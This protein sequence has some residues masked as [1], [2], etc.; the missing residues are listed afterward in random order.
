[1][2][3]DLYI[4]I[5]YGGLELNECSVCVT[6]LVM[7]HDSFVCVTW[8][9][10][11]CDMTRSYVWHAFFTH[12]IRRTRTKRVLCTCDMTHSDV[13]H[14]SSVCVT[15]LIHMC[16]MTHSYVWNDSFVC[17]TWLIPMCDI[18]YSYTR[19]GALELNE[20][21]GVWLAIQVCCSLLQPVAA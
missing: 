13:W 15:W 5:R 12:Q 1:M 4:H 21:Q 14:D 8:L 2:W 17:V 6:W 9:I 20:S 11:M 16:D 19:Y 7:W 18:N 3:H 10:R